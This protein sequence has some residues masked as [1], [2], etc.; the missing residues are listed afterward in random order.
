MATEADETA[1]VS[2]LSFLVAYW[3]NPDSAQQM[4]KSINEVRFHPFTSPSFSQANDDIVRFP[5]FVGVQDLEEE[6]SVPLRFS[7]H[8]C[9]RLAFTHLSMVTRQGN[10]RSPTLP[11]STGSELTESEMCVNEVPPTR[12][13]RFIEWFS[14]LTLREKI[15]ITYKSL[16]STSR[17]LNPNWVSTNTTMNEV[18]RP[19]L[20]SS[21]DSSKKKN[22]SDSFF[23]NDY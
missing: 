18:V 13:I 14:Q 9:T 15:T 23:R 19:S 7:H 22:S 4:Y 10:V 5:P 12:I 6:F 21:C 1:T 17:S 11:Y 3:A 20:T 8:S 16:L 2:L